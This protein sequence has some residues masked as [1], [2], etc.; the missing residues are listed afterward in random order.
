MRLG[1]R[2]APERPVRLRLYSETPA[3]SVWPLIAPGCYFTAEWAGIVTARAIFVDPCR[4][5]A[6]TDGISHRRRHVP[7]G[8]LPKMHASSVPGTDPCIFDPAAIA[9]FGTRTPP[10]SGSPPHR[11]GRLRPFENVSVSTL[12]EVVAG[13]LAVQERFRCPSRMAAR[14]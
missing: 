13:V 1:Q 3:A 5:R 12:S 2:I 6:C 10:H 4:R 11:P 14:P 7:V 9:R 8:N